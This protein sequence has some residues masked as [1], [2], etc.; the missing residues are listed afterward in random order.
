[1]VRRKLMS[2]RGLDIM[3][4]QSA[5]EYQRCMAAAAADLGF[6]FFSSTVVLNHSP[7]LTEFQSIHNVPAAYEESFDNTVNSKWDPVGQFCKRSS[8]LLLWNQETYVSEGVGDLWEAQAKFGYRAGMAKAS[9]LPLG[10]HFWCGFDGDRALPK[11]RALDDVMEQFRML[12]THAQDAAFR[13]LA[14]E[15][16]PAVEGAALNPFEL[17]A[18]RWSMEGYS[19]SEVGDLM[20]LSDLYI[21]HHLQNAVIKLGCTTKHQAV[22]KAIRLRLLA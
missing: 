6:S 19:P 4:A 1:M 20:R 21:R 15:A 10:R 13:I 17:E 22:L 7:H 5:A 14:P 12:F 3:Q 9:H 8:A 11:G 16:A 2:G 18:L